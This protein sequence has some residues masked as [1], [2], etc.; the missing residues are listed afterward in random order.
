MLSMVLVFTLFVAG[1]AM[2]Q[3]Q[4]GQRTPQT[5]EQRLKRWNDNIFSKLD[6]KNDQ[7]SKVE[8][9]FT[10][11]FGK[12]DSL[13]NSGERP[14]WD[15]VQKLVAERDEKVKTVLSEEQFKKYQEMVEQQMQQMRQRRGGGQG[16]GPGGGSG[17]NRPQQ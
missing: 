12:Q 8:K 16:G 7:Q 5:I 13:R 3:G 15:D 6:L 17:G 10:E 1:T 2:A 14:S 4:R 11:Y 9:I